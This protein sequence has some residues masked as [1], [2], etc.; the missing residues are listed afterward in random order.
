[1][2]NNDWGRGAADAFSG[3]LKSKG[4]E[5]GVME[6]MDAGAQDMSAQLA[7]I[8]ASGSDTLFIPRAWSSSP[9][10]LKQAKEQQLPQQIITTGGSSRPTSSS[11]RPERQRTD[12]SISSSSLRGFPSPRPIPRWPRPLWPSGTNGDTSS[13]A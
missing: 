7:K 9:L 2:V 11:S 13:R 4:I 1:M 8:K 5:V 3:M 6:I 10:V 12:R